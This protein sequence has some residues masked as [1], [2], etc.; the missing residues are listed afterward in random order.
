[1]W[2]LFIDDKRVPK[3]PNEFMV[4]RSWKSAAKMIRQYGFPSHI[5]FDYYLDDHG[6]T[7]M[8]LLDWIHYHQK[9]YPIPE[10]FSY[11]IHSSYS[12]AKKEIG[13][14]LKSMGNFPMTG[15]AQIGSFDY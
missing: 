13:A 5:A 3:N 14:A 11:S 15:R 8:P 12:G 2:K 7:V 6:Q 1:M 9:D 4:A 10:N